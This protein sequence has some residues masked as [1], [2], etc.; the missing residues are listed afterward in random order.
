MHLPRRHAIRLKGRLL[1]SWSYFSNY[2]R[3][4]HYKAQSM[5]LDLIDPPPRRKKESLID[6]DPKL[7]SNP[8]G[9]HFVRHQEY[10]LST[11]F[12]STL[13]VPG[14]SVDLIQA[15]SNPLA[16][17]PKAEAV[18]GLSVDLIQAES[19]P[20]VDCTQDQAVSVLSVG[21]IQAESNPLV[22]CA[23]DRDIAVLSVDL[24]SP[25]NIKE[26]FTV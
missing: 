26:C 5:R 11:D 23:Q 3:P 22:D 9:A 4:L 17:C 6:Q 25:A 1:A 19:N 21:L 13:G 18:P 20:L 2:H 16:H 8:F 12:P 7:E 24:L 10:T 14:L 15:E